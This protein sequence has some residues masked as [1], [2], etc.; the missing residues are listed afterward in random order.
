MT[1]FPYPTFQLRSDCTVAKR[2]YEAITQLKQSDYIIPHFSI[3][4]TLLFN[5]H[6]ICTI[7]TLLNSGVDIDEYVLKETKD[8]CIA[9][10]AMHR[11]DLSTLS[12]SNT[13]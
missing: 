9:Q 5:I 6:S 3:L 11:I 10:L 2:L 7:S 4:L 1:V 13:I 8:W 12:G